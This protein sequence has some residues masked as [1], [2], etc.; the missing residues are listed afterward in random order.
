MLLDM[1]CTEENGITYE[2]FMNCYTTVMAN[3][4][5]CQNKY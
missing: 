4:L 5:W 1:V 3:H 2:N